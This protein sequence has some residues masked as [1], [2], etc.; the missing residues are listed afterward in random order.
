MGSRNKGTVSEVLSAG[1]GGRPT[2]QTRLTCPNAGL[3]NALYTVHRSRAGG[4]PDVLVAAVVPLK[5]ACT[6]KEMVLIGSSDSL[7]P[8]GAVTFS[9]SGRISG[10][11]FAGLPGFAHGAG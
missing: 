6:V 10:C 2:S 7:L 9:R 1:H 5:P 3:E 8:T 4:L 11:S